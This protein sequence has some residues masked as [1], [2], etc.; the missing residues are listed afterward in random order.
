[1]TR[2]LRFALRDRLAGQP[3]LWRGYRGLRKRLLGEARGLGPI[4]RVLES[5]ARECRPVRFVQVGSNDAA[6]DDPIIDFVLGWGWQGLMIEP[7]PEVYE[8]LRRRYRFNPRLRFAYLAIGASEGWRSFYCLEPLAHPP[9]PYYD[10]LG[11][12]SRAHI[13][14]HER[15]IP[16]ISRHIREIEVPVKPLAAV[17]REQGISAPEL[18]HVDAEGADF[19]VL[20]SLDFEVCTPPLLLFEHG[21]LPRTE[22]E[23]CWTWLAARGYRLLQEGRDCLA[24]HYSGRSR[25]PQTATLFDA[26][27]PDWS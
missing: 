8:R 10:Q 27:T 4:Q 15:F 16:G 3:L 14:K 23:A 18:L 11:S 7:V 25:W 5:F 21:H 19:E 9:S 6:H 22:F 13:E 20:Q 26:N 12:F 2:T 24:L 17:L 1:M